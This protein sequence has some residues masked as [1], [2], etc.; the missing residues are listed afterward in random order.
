MEHFYKKIQGWFSYPNLYKEAVAK[1][2]SG[3]KFVEVGTWKGTSAAF[4][5]VEIINA[6][7]DI[8]LDCVDL[9]TTE[10][11]HLLK[12]VKD[13]AENADNKDWL[14]NTFLANTASVKHMLNPIRGFSDKSAALYEDSSVDF[15]FIDAAHDYESV[16]KDL[17]AW[18]PKIKSG[19]TF[20]GHD[21]NQ[22]Q[23]AKAVNEF[24]EKRPETVL[25]GEICWKTYKQ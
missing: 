25:S 6:G 21:Y 22:S 7:K 1:Y 15:C 14:Y 12:V 10:D 13:Y 5:A 16:L 18:Y 19:G 9:W 24:F 11:T 4:M 20:A 8:V 2:P 3:S 17:T 23:V